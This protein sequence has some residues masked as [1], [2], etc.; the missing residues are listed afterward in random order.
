MN[1]DNKD[2]GRSITIGIQPMLIMVHINIL[3]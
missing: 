3:V 2:S 1:P